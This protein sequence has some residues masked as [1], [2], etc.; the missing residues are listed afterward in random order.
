MPF[1]LTTTRYTP[2]KPF[3]TAY[4]TAITG[5]YPHLPAGFVD[6]RA[7]HEISRLKLIHDFRL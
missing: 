6:R 7:T 5:C 4:P 3:F 1:T 2:K